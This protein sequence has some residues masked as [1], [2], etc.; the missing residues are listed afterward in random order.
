MNKNKLKQ[1]A[2][3]TF[4][5]F[6]THPDTAQQCLDLLDLQSF[7]LCIE[8]SAGTGS[9]YN[10]L[11]TESRFGVELDP[12][13]AD[14]ISC[15]SWYDHTWDK[16]N[17]LVVGN[18]P[19]GTQNQEAIRFFNHAAK[20]AECIAFI[21]P[22]T[23]KRPSI[24]NSLDLNFHLTHSHDL[25]NAFYGE[26]ITSAKC[27]FQIWTRKASPR[28][29]VKLPITHPDWQFLKYET[30]DGDLHPPADADFVVLAYGSNPGQMSDDLY[31]WR[32]KSVHFIKANIDCDELKQR[33]A[34]LDYSI[35][36][37]SARQSSLGKGALV[38]LYGTQYD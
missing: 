6:F 11:P 4:D 33:F 3:Y 26:K 23:W 29:K 12:R 35:A 36:N 28:K 2:V 37:D 21:I 19:F 9:F 22:R 16:G 10:L 31:R 13:L 32:P 34:A 8:P 30:K 1:D 17:I 27:C 24:Q 38:T 25:T 15:G 5:Q 7:D 20:F 14:G 18:P